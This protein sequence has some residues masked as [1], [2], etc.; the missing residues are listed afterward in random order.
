LLNQEDD[1]ALRQLP[2]HHADINDADQDPADLPLSLSLSLLLL[3]PLVAA[4]NPAISAAA[5]KA[6]HA[7]MIARL[8]AWASR[9]SI[10][11]SEAMRRLLERAFALSRV[12]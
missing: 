2:D 7:G 3:C 11:R 8:D 4:A 9:E 5:L 10:G 1:K 12:T 6:K